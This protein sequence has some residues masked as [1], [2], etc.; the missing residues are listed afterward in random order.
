MVLGNRK[1]RGREIAVKR[2]TVDHASIGIVALGL[3]V[4]IMAVRRS[5]VMSVVRY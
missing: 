2:R 3:R 5:R 4:M 1:I